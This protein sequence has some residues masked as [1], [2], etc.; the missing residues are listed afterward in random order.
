MTLQNTSNRMQVYTL[1]HVDSCK[2]ECF[3]TSTEHAQTVHDSKTGV[4]SLRM[5]PMLVPA[6]VYLPVG[7]TVEL[8]DSALTPQMQADI[9]NKI[10]SVKG[11]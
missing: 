9:D 4:K 11:N 7:E 8:S 2:D 6:A 3:C 10:L 5:I 1:A